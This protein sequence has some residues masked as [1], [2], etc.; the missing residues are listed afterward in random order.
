MPPCDLGRRCRELVSVLWLR[1]HAHDEATIHPVTQQ[2]QLDTAGLPANLRGTSASA[3]GGVAR[4]S[5]HGSDEI[6]EVP[7]EFL[8][9]VRAPAAASTTMPP[10]TRL[11]GAASI[12]PPPGRGG[13]R[14]RMAREEGLSPRVGG[15]G[16]D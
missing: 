6:S 2:R 8:R 11:W 4:I 1:D 5:W 15:V 10:Q 12:A 14:P 13:D 7:V 3:V 9:R 16:P